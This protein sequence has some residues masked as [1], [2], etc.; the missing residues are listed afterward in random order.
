[1]ATIPSSIRVMSATAFAV[2]ALAAATAQAQVRVTALSAATNAQVTADPTPP[3]PFQNYPYECFSD[4]T[5]LPALSEL[6]GSNVGAGTSKYCRLGWPRLDFAYDAFGAVVLNFQGA[7]PGPLS[8]APVSSLAISA[9]AAVRTGGDNY[10]TG[11]TGSAQALFSA[12]FH[13]ATPTSVTVRMM[14]QYA[15]SL[16]IDLPGVT[17]P[18]SGPVP[19]P[20]CVPGEGSCFE[21]VRYEKTVLFGPGTFTVSGDASASNL[22]TP[23]SAAVSFEFAPAPRRPVLLLPG[24]GGTSNALSGSDLPW[25]LF[26]GV[27]PSILRLDPL[28][29]SYDDLIATLEAAGYQQGVDLFVVPYDWR[30][31]IG[32]DDGTIDGTIDGLSASGLSDQQYRYAV[33]YLGDYLRR[34]AEVWSARYPDGPPLDS[35]DVIAHSTGGLVARTYIQSS[36][37]GGDYA[38]GLALPR[39]GRLMMIGVPNR[40]ASKAWNP[41]HDNW[42]IDVAYR[43]VL[44]K[45]VYRAYQLVKDKNA[46]VAGPDH[47]IT[48]AGLQSPTECPHGPKICFIEQYIPAARSLLATYDFLDLGAGPSTVNLDALQR[49]SL[50]LDLNAGLDHPAGPTGD[51]N[52]FAGLA[53]VTVIYGTNGGSTPVTVTQDQ[54]P[55]LVSAIASFSDSIVRPA[56]I[57]EPF[58]RDDVAAHAGDGTVPLESAIGQF[59]ND[60]RV[61]LV[62]FTRAGFFTESVGHLPLLYNTAVQQEV[63]ATLG[64][65]AGT[66]ISTNRH[67][68]D[69]DEIACAASGCLNVILDPV[70]GFVVDGLGRRL[71]FTAATGPLTEIPGSYWSGDA[72]GMGWILGNLVPPLTLQLTGLG[73]DYMAQVTTLSSEGAGGVE[74]R[75]SLAAGATRAVTVPLSVTPDT[76]NPTAVLSAPQSILAGQDLAVSGASSHDP[77]GTVV[78]YRWTLTGFAS[79]ETSEPTFTFTA[80]AYPLP[81][82]RHQVQLVV[83]DAS[84]NQSSPDMRNVDV[85]G[86]TINPT[87]VLDAPRSVVEGHPLTVTGDRSF[88]PGGVIRRYYWQLDSLPEVET[89]EATF[90][91]DRPTFT[92][93]PGVHIVGLRVMDNAGNLSQAHQLSVEV[94]AD[95]RPTAVLAAPRTIDRGD[96]LPLD[97]SNSYDSVG[98]IVRYEWTLDALATVTTTDATFTFTA[99]AYDLAVGRHTV[100]LAVVDDAGQRSL[101][102]TKAVDV[103]GDTTNPTAVLEG[104]PSIVEGDDLVLTGDRSIDI[105]GRIV[106]YEWTV[107]AFAVVETPT[108]AFTFAAANY[109]LGVGDHTVSLVVVDD[110]GNRSSPDVRRVTVTARADTVQLHLRVDGLG[111]LPATTVVRATARYLTLPAGVSDPLLPS[112][113]PCTNAIDCLFAPRAG[114]TVVIDVDPGGNLLTGPFVAGWTGCDAQVNGRCYVSPTANRTVSVRVSRTRPVSAVG[115]TGGAL[116]SSAAGPGV[117]AFAAAR[118][119]AGDLLGGGAVVAVASAQYGCGAVAAVER[120]GNR[121]TLVTRYGVKAPSAAGTP[122]LNGYACRI[123]VTDATSRTARDQ[124]ALEVIAPSGAVELSATGSASYLAFVTLTNV[125]VVW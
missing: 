29:R 111:G 115:T 15:G 69:I 46:V 72:D 42:S 2:V 1:M 103:I 94:I 57:G 16:S 109:P 85:L 97:G 100:A 32:P 26:R 122:P 3:E 20:G 89:V 27:G 108:P 106:R 107:D 22:L 117:L 24:I 76:T 30:L 37:Y 113:P 74:V 121:T 80:A 36:A 82:G 124:F 58:Y 12:T 21:D 61:R 38:P 48:W 35:V 47:V 4:T 7:G 66:A 105:G 5:P 78:A 63:L 34:A 104:P 118:T 39:I 88:D 102:D 98:R 13:V 6:T 52:A 17:V 83:V 95:T 99:V 101:A 44:S 79:V 71:G 84:G 23:P 110:S 54:G 49:N 62:P 92:L 119:A 18:P 31:E 86:D 112:A 64:I 91:F 50:L 9:H 67:G 41:L 25:L 11:V 55:A 93:A 33:D 45:I 123:A 59:L 53:D 14:R 77:G 65:P 56:V 70:E 90:T 96:D 73:G 40:G 68:F 116:F 75:G 81:P 8:V 43:L 51:P 19:I 10:A 28:T 114:S 87:A 120:S 125:P 60:P